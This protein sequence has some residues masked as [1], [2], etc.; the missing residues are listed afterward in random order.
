[1]NSSQFALSGTAFREPVVITDVAL[2]DGLQ[3]QPEQVSTSDK[4]ALLRALAAAGVGSVEA[5]SF[6]SPK[7]VPQMADAGEMMLAARDLAPLRVSALTPNMKGLERAIAAGTR[8]IAVVLSCTETM[9]LKNINMSLEQATRA[10]CDTLQAAR[11]HGVAT[12]AYLAVAFECPFEGLTPADRVYALAQSLLEAGAD[13]I[14]IADTIGAAAPGQVH[15]LVQGLAQTLPVARMGLHVHDTRGM[16]VANAY[17]A[18]QLGVRR[19]DASVGGL[20]GCPFAP[21]ASGNLATEDLVLM[22]EQSG[23]DTGISLSGLLAAVDLTS[24]LLGRP[25]GGNCTTWLRRQLA[26]AKSNSQGLSS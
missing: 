18:L 7:A 10:S 12:R 9:N 21:G 16:G 22:L 13:E 19:F 15:Q 8:E 5:A 20:G 4:L 6:V 14:V 23:F 26:K 1:M 17:A 2:R 25:Q 3:N 11:G 24:E